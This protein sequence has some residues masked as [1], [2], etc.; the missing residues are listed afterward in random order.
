MQGMRIKRTSIPTVNNYN[1][2]PIT[3]LKKCKCCFTTVTF[4]V[5]LTTVFKLLVVC[6]NI[7]KYSK[8]PVTQT[9]T[10]YNNNRIY[11]SESS[12][13]CMQK[14]QFSDVLI[15]KYQHEH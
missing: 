4:S 13:I 12:Q 5:G 14:S 11:L 2:A 1:N 8:E 10:Y 9:P 7:H 3:W 15:T 6:I